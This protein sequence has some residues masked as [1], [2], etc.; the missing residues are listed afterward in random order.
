MW[1]RHWRGLEYNTN[2]RRGE[3]PGGITLS[4]SWVSSWVPCSNP[5]PLSTSLPC[6]PQIGPPWPPAARMSSFHFFL[7]L[8]PQPPFLPIAPIAPIHP[9]YFFPGTL[10]DCQFP[11]SIRSW[12]LLMLSEAQALCLMYSHS[13]TPSLS[14]WVW[15]L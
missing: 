4:T 6:P 13:T 7:F 10:S 5:G 3:D 9:I 15:G 2:Q 14:V 12:K 1:L 8:P 11:T